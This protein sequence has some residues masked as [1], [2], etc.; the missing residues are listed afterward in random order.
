[1]IDQPQGAPPREPAFCPGSRRVLLVSPPWTTPYSTC[2]ALGLLKPILEEA[3]I[4]TEVLYGSLLFPPPSSSYGMLE[5]YASF[6]FLPRLHPDVEPG[7][8]SRRV[9]EWYAHELNLRGVLSDSPLESLTWVGIDQARLGIEIQEDMEKAGICLERCLV[10]AARSEYD[11]VGFSLGFETQVTPALALARRLK[12]TNPEVKIALG[13]AACMGEQA[14]GLVS[15]FPEVDAVCHTEGE[16][17]VVAMVRALRGEVPMAQV[18]G[19]AYLDRDG[20]LQH[21]PSPPLVEEMDSLPVPVYDDFFAQHRESEWAQALPKVFFETSRGCW[22]GQKHP[23]AFCGLNAQGLAFRKKTPQRAF[24]EIEQLYRSSPRVQCFQAADNVL[25]REYSRTLF[26]M[27]AGMERLPDRPFQLFF[28]VRT[29]LDAGQLAQL[30]SCGVGMVQAGIESFSDEIL[31]LMNKGARA[32]QQVQFLK[33]ACQEGMPLLYNLLICTPGEEARHY[34]EMSDLL[35]YVSHLPPP[36]SVARVELERFSP[37]H[38]RPGDYGISN[39][40]PKSYYGELFREAGADLQRIAYQFSYD[41]P[42]FEDPELLDAQRDFV[43]GVLAWERGWKHMQAFYVDRGDHLVVLD[44]RG[45][46]QGVDILSG[47]LAELFRFLDRRR[48]RGSVHRRF[49]DVDGDFLDCSLDAWLHRRW[50]CRDLEDGLLAVLPKVRE[51]TPHPV[52][53]LVKHEG[54]SSCPSHS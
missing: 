32:L 33:W 5:R 40:R 37:Y 30:R 52:P 49:D 34:R 39:V 48:S 44:R 24:V 53:A 4:G 8:L 42:L 43:R 25:P 26:P 12:A 50:L 41:H 6:L 31:G 21:N 22:W 7:E 19:I 54:G 11:V 13:G 36:S 3:G 1:M 45:E 2:L 20:K 18:P 46:V 38:R 23:C 27:L 29:D 9:T 14:D 35:P 51:K 28:E 10:R 17:V 16:R 47:M 15:S